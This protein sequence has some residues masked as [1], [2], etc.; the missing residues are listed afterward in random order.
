MKKI[1][2]IQG[3]DNHSSMNNRTHWIPFFWYS[4]DPYCLR[5]IGWPIFIVPEPGRHL[6]LELHRSL[7]ET[8]NSFAKFKHIACRTSVPCWRLDVDIHIIQFTVEKSLYNIS[9]K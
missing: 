5:I 9:L 1:I 6:L 3:M 2:C 8:I 4:L 7:M